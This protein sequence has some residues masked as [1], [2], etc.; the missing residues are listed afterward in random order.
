MPFE[1]AEITADSEFRELVEVEWAAYEKPLCKLL[2]LFF[3]T[4][5][6]DPDS[7]ASALQEGVERQ[8]GWHNNDPTSHWVKVVDRET[9]RLV[10]AACWH[11]YTKNPYSAPADDECTWFPAGEERE[12]ANS[13]MGQFV[14]SR[15]KYMAKAHVCMI[16]CLLSRSRYC[17]LTYRNQVLDIC[18]VH[19]E[20]RRKGVGRLLLSWGIEKAD[21]LGLESYI[22]ATDQ[23]IPLYEAHGYVKAAGVNFHAEQEKRS[24]RWH[25]LR[26]VLLPFTFW[27]MW[28]PAGGKFENGTGP[29]WDQAI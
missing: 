1:L 29:P 19:P 10:G 5:G 20:Y 25:E 13:L 2:N 9:G 6:I 16:F 11:V 26:G 12:M 17:R 14:A 18:F 22:D 4:R 7:R 23:G 3:P 27:P 21:E 24:P 28:R 15:K 8:S